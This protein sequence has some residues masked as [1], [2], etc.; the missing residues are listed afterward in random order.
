AE[1]FNE[2]FRDHVSE[3]AGIANPVLDTLNIYGTADIGAMAWETPTSIAIRKEA[4][5]DEK[6]FKALFGSLEKTP[7]LAQFNPRF[8]S[9]DTLN[10]EILLTGNNAIPLIRYAVGD[11][12]GVL[13]FSELR[14]AIPSLVVSDTVKKFDAPLFE[15]P[16]VYVFERSDFSVKLSGAII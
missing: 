16:F 9:F 11:R 13:S 10:G 3:L 1:S 15:L 4:T 7:T 14:K 5:K 6:V 8:T 12:G 2:T